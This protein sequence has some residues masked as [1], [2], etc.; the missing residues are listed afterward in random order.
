MKKNQPSKTVPIYRIREL[1]EQEK[2]MGMEFYREHWQGFI[3]Q[4]WKVRHTLDDIWEDGNSE[5][6]ALEDLSLIQ[7]WVKEEKKKSEQT[8]P[9]P[10]GYCFHITS[11][12]ENYLRIKIKTEET[13]IIPFKAYLAKGGF[14]RK[15]WGVDKNQYFQTALQVGPIILDVSYNTVNLIQAKVDW[16]VLGTN[17]VFREVKDLEDYLSIKSS[18]QGIDSYWNTVFN[19]IKEDYPIIHFD[20]NKKMFF[21]PM[22]ETFRRLVRKKAS[23]KEASSPIQDL[24]QKRLDQLAKIK[25]PLKSKGYSQ[26]IYPAVIQ[27]ALL[28]LTGA[29]TT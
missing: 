3:D 10:K 16:Q 23:Q 20:R 1:S 13:W 24:D 25:E 27:K 2:E 21:L 7:A 8:N 4:I 5:R 18:Y 22:D 9:F 19:E 14:F 11:I 15:V 29:A 12:F 28:R 26:L 6:L 17:C